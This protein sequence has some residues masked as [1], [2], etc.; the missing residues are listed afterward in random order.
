MV[1]CGRHR[2]ELLIPE[3][4]QKLPDIFY[5]DALFHQPIQEARHVGAQVHKQTNEATR[6]SQD[7]GTFYRFQGGL[8]ITACHV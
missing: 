8:F 6:L 2:S 4:G 3:S 5:R 1:R 7:Q